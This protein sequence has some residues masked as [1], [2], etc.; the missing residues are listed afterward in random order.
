MHPST[1]AFHAGGVHGHRTRGRARHPRGSLLSSTTRHHFRGYLHTRTHHK[2]TRV[3]V[4][5]T[6]LVRAHRV[7]PRRVSRHRAKRFR[8]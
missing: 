3:R 7:F 4:R 1:G 6:K 8:F 2:I 5:K